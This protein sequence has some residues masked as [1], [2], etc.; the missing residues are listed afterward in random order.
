M[1][2]VYCPVKDDRIDGGDCLIACDAADNT[3]KHTVL[4]ECI[5]WSE[6]QRQK[7]LNCKYH[8]EVG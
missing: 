5:K 1:E 4:P 8:Y 3:V 2:T 6:E 7:C